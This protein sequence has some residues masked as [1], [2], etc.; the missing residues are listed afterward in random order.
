MSDLV[1]APCIARA[2]SESRSQALASALSVVLPKPVNGMF[3]P[4]RSLDSRSS[5]LE[6]FSQLTADIILD[7]TY[8][9]GFGAVRTEKFTSRRGVTR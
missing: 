6:L 4:H 8:R 1:P 2:R 5:G 7:H 9:A 3:S